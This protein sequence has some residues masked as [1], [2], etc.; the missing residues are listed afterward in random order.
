[1]SLVSVVKNDIKVLKIVTKSLQKKNVNSRLFLTR[2]NN[3][4]IN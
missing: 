2:R 4:P 3:I 1:V